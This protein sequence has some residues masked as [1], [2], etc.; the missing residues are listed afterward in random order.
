MP[1]KA[2][3]EAVLIQRSLVQG[4][5]EGGEAGDSAGQEAVFGA[6]FRAVPAGL[7]LISP[8]GQ[9]LLSNTRWREL[10][11]LNQEM[12][13]VRLDQ[14][15]C[16]CERTRLADFL[17]RIQGA[18][19]K[20]EK[21]EL[22]IERRDGTRTVIDI[23]ATALHDP[24][25]SSIAVIEDVGGRRVEEKQ[26]R[27]A[28]K[29]E[30]VGRLAGGIAHDFNNLLTGIMLYCDLLT[31]GLEQ[32]QRLRH[33]ADEIRSAAN[34][35]AELIH[36]L[37]AVARPH[38]SE[39]R[40]VSV[41]EVIS[42][43]AGMLG[44]LIGEHIELE[45]RLEDGLVAVVI[46]DAQLKQVLMNLVPNARDAIPEGG[47]ITVETAKRRARLE[48]EEL[49]PER[50]C[51]AM[52]VRDTGSGMNAETRKRLFEP[53]FTTKTAGKGN[54][55]GLATVYNIVI[56]NGGRIDVAS[57][58]GKGSEFTV[59]LPAVETAQS[60]RPAKEFKPESKTTLQISDRT[61][62]G[63]AGAQAAA[64]FEVKAK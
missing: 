49:A 42:E 64:P 63:P 5:A 36:Q 18:T 52:K 54:G 50:D 10:L 9:V 23:T 17:S 3:A 6:I 51:V 26:L 35:G 47:R 15:I 56:Q 19:S 14:L 55:L 59:L 39:P 60:C 57:E 20:T 30:A 32:N 45:T 24:E 38:P 13:E 61:A 7:A 16:D 28:H 58:A 41:N 29:M 1:G 2:L 27:E 22:Q 25:N 48:P 44:R 31:M 53:F 43:M 46:D 8:E 37:L 21:C 33:H 11:G 12:P 62:A 34:Q 4:L 40:I